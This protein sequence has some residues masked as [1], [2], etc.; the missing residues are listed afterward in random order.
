MSEV[1]PQ[2]LI[3]VATAAAAGPRAARGGRALAR[4]G[5][6]RRFLDDLF[7]GGPVADILEQAAGYGVS[8]TGRQV[9]TVVSPGAGPPF[10]DGSALLRTIERSLHDRDLD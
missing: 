5:P 3:A 2:Q 7:E 1:S 4:E 9:V 10:A 8:L 6:R